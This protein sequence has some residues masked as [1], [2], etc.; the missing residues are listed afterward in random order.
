V[1]SH[2]VDRTSH[3]E[4]SRYSGTIHQGGHFTSIADTH[5]LWDAP[6]EAV[7]VRCR[8]EVMH[9]NLFMV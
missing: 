1:D 6:S 9:R 8:A 3:M 5:I 2:L 4:G 7:T